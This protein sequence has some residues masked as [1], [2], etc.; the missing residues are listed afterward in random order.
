MTFLLL[1]SRI[2]IVNKYYCH[3]LSLVWFVVEYK[4]YQ[5]NCYNYLFSYFQNEVYSHNKTYTTINTF[6]Q[7]YYHTAI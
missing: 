2:V 3:L 6:P 7:Y 5:S 4:A 1:R